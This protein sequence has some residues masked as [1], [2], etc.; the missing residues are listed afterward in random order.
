MCL[1]YISYWTFFGIAIAMLVYLSVEMRMSIQ[2]NMPRQKHLT[3]HPMV[4]MVHWKHVLPAVGVMN[5]RR[6]FKMF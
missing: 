3:V 1:A 6:C 5:G 2:V 4:P